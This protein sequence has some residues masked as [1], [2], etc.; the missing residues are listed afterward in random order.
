MSLYGALPARFRR[1]RILIVGCGDVGQRVARELQG[2]PIRLLALTS[3]PQRVDELRRQGLTPLVGNLDDR[4]SLGRLA[5]LA[6]RVLHLA[7][8]PGDA[9]D[10]RRDPRTRELVRALMQ[11]S[12][13]QAL[14]YGSTTG[15]YGDR[16][17]RWTSESTPCSPLTPRAWRRV[18]A[19]ATVRW[20]GRITGCRSH[21]EDIVHEAFLK[22][23]EADASGPIRSQASY[24]TRIVRNLS[25]DLL[26]RT[27]LENRQPDG[28]E[29]LDELPSSAPSPEHQALHRD[30]LRVLQDALA[31]LPERA[32]QAFHMHRLQHMTFQEIAARLNISTSLAH[33]LVRDALT[34][35][36]EHLA[37]D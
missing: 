2:R 29:R 3:S 35:C 23:G 30:Q 16:Q 17:G 15:V 34:H 26:R 1:Q 6:T 22:M 20:F 37:D 14:V 36:A 27:T 18:D 10:W 8:P 7:P 12:A 11:R 21:A 5:G 13:P 25:F 4:R 24:L 31:L 33:Q 19:E 9:G 28:G 32:R